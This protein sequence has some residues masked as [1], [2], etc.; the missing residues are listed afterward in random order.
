MP[1][2]L[3]NWLSIGFALILAPMLLSLAFRISQ[4]DHLAWLMVA[5]VLYLAILGFDIVSRNRLGLAGATGRWVVLAFAIIVTCY[6]GYE[7]YQMFGQ[8]PPVRVS[9][10]GQNL[11]TFGWLMAII[12]PYLI[13]AQLGTRPAVAYLTPEPKPAAA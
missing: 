4:K 7:M 1:R 3:E 8:N 9:P 13:F 11:T 12:G 10:I 6:G 2:G 5:G